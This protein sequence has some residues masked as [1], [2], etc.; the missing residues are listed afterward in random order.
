MY[1]LRFYV[2]YLYTSEVRMKSAFY[3]VIEL[4]LIWHSED[5]K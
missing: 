2:K 1:E 4:R 5:T 3:K